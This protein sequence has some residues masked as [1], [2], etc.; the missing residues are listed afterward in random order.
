MSDFWQ[1]VQEQDERQQWDEYQNLLKHDE[2]YSRWL[3]QMN[4]QSGGGI[5]T[6]QKSNL[7]NNKEEIVI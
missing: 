1:Q 2:G 6:E 7:N 4:L 3:N 5:I